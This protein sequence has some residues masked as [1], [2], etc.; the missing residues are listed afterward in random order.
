MPGLN[1]NEMHAL[2]DRN[3]SVLIVLMLL[4]KFTKTH[5]LLSN[6]K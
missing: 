2:Y 3:Q 5:T 1:A 4:K 6:T